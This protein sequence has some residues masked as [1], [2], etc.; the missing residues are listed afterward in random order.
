MSQIDKIIN[1][2]GDGLCL[3]RSVLWSLRSVCPEQRIGVPWTPLT[4]RQACAVEMKTHP[5]RYI[6]FLN[7]TPSE[8]ERVIKNELE[9]GDWTGDI[10]DLVPKAISTV[11]CYSICIFFMNN[12]P[13]MYVYP[14]GHRDVTSTV[15]YIYY[16][17]VNHYDT[18]EP[19][20][21]HLL[22]EDEKCSN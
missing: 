17:G 18:A 13:S 11:L 22:S 15:A 16:N 8:F 7:Y 1:V 3:F 20:E 2:P 14:H 4:L 19:S 6:E 21:L 12:G 9:H 5:N 10:F